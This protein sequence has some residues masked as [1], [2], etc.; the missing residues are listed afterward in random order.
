LFVDQLILGD[1]SRVTIGDGAL[2]QVNQVICSSSSDYAC[3][4]MDGGRLGKLQVYGTVT[5]MEASKLRLEGYNNNEPSYYICTALNKSN[6]SMLFQSCVVDPADRVSTTIDDLYNFGT[7]I[8]NDCVKLSC[9]YVDQ[10]GGV[11]IW[12]LKIGTE[13]NFGHLVWQIQQSDVNTYSPI[14]SG[15]EVGHEDMTDP[16]RAIFTVS[17]NAECI[18]SRRG[19]T[20]TPYKVHGKMVIGDA[21]KCT[22]ELAAVLQFMKGSELSLEGNLDPNTN[23]A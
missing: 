7:F 9:G 20:Q 18:F 2:L 4:N 23:G 14:T 6:A 21:S 5:N 1:R 19:F 22:V 17:N 12:T 15:F 16:N 11:Q 13:N 8:V 3:I 10:I